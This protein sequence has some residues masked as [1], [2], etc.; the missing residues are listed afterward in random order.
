MVDNLKK[1]EAI[2]EIRSFLRAFGYSDAGF[3]AALKIYDHISG[4]G[5]YPVTIK[6]IYRYFYGV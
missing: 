5:L 3:F 6:T 2:S 1:T 4:A